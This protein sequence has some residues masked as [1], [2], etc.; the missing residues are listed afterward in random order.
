MKTK[1]S[2]PRKTSRLWVGISTVNGVQKRSIFRHVGEPKKENYP[3]F[4]AAIGP[5]RT[6]AGA[7]YLSTHFYCGS[8]AKAEQMA[9]L[10]KGQSQ[11]CATRI[12]FLNKEIRA[13]S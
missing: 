5:F 13:K 3:D 2:Y 6:K 12:D 11:L 9:K 8:V 7:E 1:D 4:S 10:H